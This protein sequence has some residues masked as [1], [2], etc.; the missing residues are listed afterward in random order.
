MR[1]VF[2]SLFFVL[3][4]TLA[5]AQSS[6]TIGILSYNLLNFPN[7]RNDC[8]TNVNIP[9]RH[10]TLRKILH[11]VKPDIFVACE[12]QT[13][14]GADSILTRSLNVNGV[15]NYKKAN[16]IPNTSSGNA[17]NNMLYYNDNK[18]TL[19]W[20]DVIQTS[21]RDISHYVL[22]VKDPNLA[23]HLDT[24]FYEVYMCHLKAGSSTADQT[25]RNAES[26]ALRAYMDARP[27]NRNHIV[28]GDLNVYR[29]T[30]AC[31][32]TLTTGGIRPVKD[33]INMPGTWTSNSSFAAIHTQSTRTSG[34][35]DCGSTGGMDDRFDQ[36]LVTDNVLAGTNSVKFLTGSYKAIGNDGNHYNQAINAGSNSMYPDS[37][38][39]AVFYTSDHLPVFMKTVAYFPT[40]NGLALTYQKTP[41]TCNGAN[42]GTA[43]VTPTYGTA[44]FTYNWG[45]NAGNQN[46]AT[47]INLAPGYYCV[48]VTD[49]TGLSDQVCLEIIEPSVIS[50]GAFP[51][52]PT[53]GCNGS[54]NV[55][56][57]GGLS[58]YT[59]AWNDPMAQTTATATGLCAGNYTCT[60]TDA[61]G[62]S[63]PV[64]VNLQSASLEEINAQLFAVYPNPANEKLFIQ[65]KDSKSGEWT[66]KMY[67]AE[68]KQIQ[69]ENF[70][71]VVEDGALE[72]N[73]EGLD[74]GIY[75]LN[76]QF[77]QKNYYYKCIKN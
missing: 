52:N 49:F 36:I 23:N 15:T 7:G 58:P 4:T 34:S 24:I 28:C 66:V 73:V 40:S 63:V 33:P 17:L 29:S 45:A 31:Y 70:G 56:V 57:N 26:Q 37:V 48:T 67:S 54:A 42:D 21:V 35:M 68:G 47:A 43:T 69:L 27:P 16:Y 51:S 71:T 9:S 19:L 72:L 2:Y 41:V 5:F 22:Y 46:T 32:Q 12:I 1:Y 64:N 38:V 6:D 13:K 20:Q 25:Q 59:Y 62:C 76:I 74:K 3:F 44:P 61:A 75:W 60:V 8:G 10:D 11:Y 77:D 14:A 39:R 53:S 65:M 18:L 55:V 30:E 50:A